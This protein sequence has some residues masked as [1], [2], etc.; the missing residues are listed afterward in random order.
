MAAPDSPSEG[1]EEAPEQQELAPLEGAERLARVE[2]LRKALEESG[3][4][5]PDTTI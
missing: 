3:D 4:G 2:E 1:E 5:A